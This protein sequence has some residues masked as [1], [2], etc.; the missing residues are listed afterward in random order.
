MRGRAAGFALALLVATASAAQEPKLLPVDEGAMDPT[1]P[2]FKARLIEALARRDQR[3]LL[4]SVDPKIR[5]VP[6]RLNLKSCGSRNLRRARCG[7]KSPNFYF[8]AV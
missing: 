8:L 5:N 1:W 3:F 2:R 7:M 6:V 4:D